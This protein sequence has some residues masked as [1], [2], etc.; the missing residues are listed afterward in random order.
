MPIIPSETEDIPELA[1][2]PAIPCVMIPDWDVLQE[3]C[4]CQD[5]LWV[6]ANWVES[7]QDKNKNIDLLPLEAQLNCRANK[8]ATQQHVVKLL[9][10]TWTYL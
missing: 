8:L 5:K 3:L 4:S 2:H 6:Q 10:S 7:H 1:T 9:H